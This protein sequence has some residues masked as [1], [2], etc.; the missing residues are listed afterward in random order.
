[1][2][3]W[4]ASLIEYML[5]LSWAKLSQAWTVTVYSKSVFK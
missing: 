3:F 5:E 1:M 4:K 2:R